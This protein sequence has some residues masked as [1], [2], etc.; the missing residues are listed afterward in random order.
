MLCAVTSVSCDMGVFLCPRGLN[1]KSKEVMNVEYVKCGCQS[2]GDV[3][4][5]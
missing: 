3:D 5:K 1:I 4:A 2:R